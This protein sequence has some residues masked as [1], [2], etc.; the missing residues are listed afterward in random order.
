MY[1]EL[2]LGVVIGKTA[3]RVSRPEAMSYVAGYVLANDITARD[4]ARRADVPNMGTDSM[5]NFCRA[6]SSALAPRMAVAHITSD[7][8]N[9]VM[10]FT[11]ARGSSEPN[12]PLA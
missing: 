10:S 6:M 8:C 2:E 1:W 7:T 3:R 12:T 5:H 11:R 9:R 4:Q